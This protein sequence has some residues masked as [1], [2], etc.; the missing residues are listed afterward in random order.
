LHQFDL[1]LATI[2]PGK[3]IIA[4]QFTT[5]YF[6]YTAGHPIDD[7]GFIKITFRSVSDI[8]TPQ[9]GNSA[10]PN[11]CTVT[12]TGDCHIE[13]RWYSK[14]HTRPWSKAL[15]LKIHGGFLNQGE[16]ITVVF[17]DTTGGSPGW[18]MQTNCIEKF[19]FKTFVDPVATYQFKELP[20]SPALKIVPGEPGLYENPGIGGHNISDDRGAT[21]RTETFESG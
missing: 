13:P 6:T 4:G 20:I 5:L 16:Q 1:G 15:F 3:P 17:G 21:T 9:F 2:Y 14:G 12:T 19:E 10:V 11:Y 8:G 7:S 18:Q